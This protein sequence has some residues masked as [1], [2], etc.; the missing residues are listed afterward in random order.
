MKIYPFNAFKYFASNFMRNISIWPE[1]NLTFF[2]SLPHINS[3]F[4]MLSSI[5]NPCGVTIASTIFI[6]ICPDFVPRLKYF[7]RLHGNTQPVFTRQESQSAH[8]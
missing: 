6:E 2:L 8:I 1:R 5:F 3:V 4:L 7:C